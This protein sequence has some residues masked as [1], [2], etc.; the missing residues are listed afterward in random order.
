M[1]VFDISTLARRSDRRPT[2][3]E[4][5]ILEIAIVLCRYAHVAFCEYLEAGRYH[6]VPRDDVISLSD[7][8]RGGCDSTSSSLKSHRTGA[9]QRVAAV[10]DRRVLGKVPV[11]RPHIRRSGSHVL[12][13]AREISHLPQAIRAD[14]RI[15]RVKENAPGESCFSDSWGSSTTYCSV[16][17]DWLHNDLAHLASAKRACGFRVALMVHDLLP[18]VTPQYSGVDLRAYFV[19]VHQVADVVVVNSDAT[20]S[21]LRWF[22]DAHGLTVP[23]VVKLP[24]GSALRDLPQTE[25]TLPNG[26]SIPTRYVLCVGTITIRKNHQLLF[27]V[28]EQLLR[29]QG[30]ENT[31]PLLVVGTKGW[32][33]EETMSRLT[34]TP[35]F[36]GVVHHIT[37][38]TDEQIAWLYQHATFTVYP[39]HYEGW[40][41]PVSESHDFGKVCLTTDRSSLPEAGEGLAVLLDP[42]DRTSWRDHIWNYWTNTEHR[43]QHEQQ[44]NT[45]HHHITATDA[46]NTIHQLAAR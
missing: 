29:E 1:L 33:S 13:A 17:M 23:P 35:T 19:G 7:K 2:G 5:T 40:G 31:P 6:E 11:I 4:R 22:A 14:L 37:D 43:E 18:E 39:S 20:E 8:I 44:I 24:M 28:W 26:D 12:R 45:N 34:R 42:D 30:P 15:H 38:A 36:A 3:I 16:G 10:L 46:A 21:D 25:P 41:L 32:L 9:S 27:D